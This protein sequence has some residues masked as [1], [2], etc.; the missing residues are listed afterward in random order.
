MKRPLLLIGLIALLLAVFAGIPL[1][2]ELITDWWWFR[3]VGFE[4]VFVTRLTTGL[5]LGLAVGAVTFAFLYINLRLAQRGVVPDPLIPHIGKSGRGPDVV[6]LLA[7][8]SWVPALIF[9]LPLGLGAGAGWLGVR[10]FFARVPFGV[11]DPIFGRDVGWYVFTLPVLEGALDFV[12]GLAV[13]GLLL[14]LPL[15]VLRR[16]VVLVNRRVRIEPSAQWHLAGLVALLL[17]TAAVE[18][19]FVQLPSIVY[20]ATGATFG[21]GY[22]DL[23]IRM[24]ALRISAVVALLGAGFVLWGAARRTAARNTVVAAVATIAALIG[25][26][27]ASSAM[28]NFVVGPNE[29]VRETPQIEHHLAATRAAWDLDEVGVRDLTGEQELTLE[30]IRTNQGTIRNVRLWDREPLLQTM[31]QLQSIRTYYDFVAVDDDRYLVD[32]VYRQVLLAPRELNVQALPSRGFINDRLTYTHGMGLTLS[33]VN[34]VTEEGLPVLFIEDLPPVSHVDLPV[35]QPRIYFGELS[36]QWV[37]ARTGQ[38]E[39]DFPAGDENAYTTYGGTG[40]VPVGG[41]FGKLLFSIRFASLKILLS[42]DIGAESRA[43]YHRDIRTRARTALPFLQWD[44]DP[45]VVIR[46]DGRL[47][48]MLDAYTASSRYPYAE[49]LSDGTNYLRNSVKVVIDAFDG[50]IDA[51]VADP[52]DPIIQAYEQIFAGIFQPLDAMPADLRAHLRYPDDLFRVQTAL[53]TLYHMENPATFYQREDQWQIPPA[54]RDQSQGGRDPFLRHIVMKLP[55]EEREEF[56]AMTPFT[57]R[58][59]DNLAAWMV[60][61]MDGDR[62]GEL[63]VYRFPRQSLV[64]GP[65]QMMSRMDQDTEIS[66]QLTLWDQRGTEVIRGNLLVIPIEESLIYVQ[67]IYLRA[68]GGR[69]PELKRVVVAYQNQ[70]VMELTLDDALAVL[71]GGAPEADQTLPAARV[72]AAAEPAGAPVAGR[73]AALVTDAN[74]EYERAIAAQQRGDWATYGE[75][76]RRVGEILAELRRISR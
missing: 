57:P 15:Y 18:T 1:G 23:A 14:T 20:S 38:E 27:V 40:G 37:F 33:P 60:A 59:K 11:E 35:T 10:R 48:W 30:D 61:R 66:Q 32:G 13:L 44:G 42:A 69:I 17:V 53:Y 19:W 21:A 29:L 56:I 67:A 5:G 41:L 39:F 63:V 51:Y 25:G 4:T 45:Y 65:R 46:E 22:T 64:F 58:E 34:L 52:D 28:Q 70:V 16:D 76:M 12:L 24:P 68:E 36:N 74:D 71:F 50:T 43:L 55:G 8:L 62:Y 72:A 47:A 75:A 2:A 49:P 9:A 7:R 54:A 31:G 3:A 26:A 73:A 6:R